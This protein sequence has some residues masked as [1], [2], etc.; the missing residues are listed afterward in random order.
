MYQINS[1]EHP[2]LVEHKYDLNERKEILL[3]K[4]EYMLNYK[5]DITI[6]SICKEM[7]I[8]PETLRNWGFNSVVAEMKSKQKKIKLIKFKKN[9]VDS[10]NK[11]INENKDTMISPTN[12]YEH[13]GVIRTVLWRSSPEITKLLRQEVVQHNMKIRKEQSY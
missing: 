13:L 3:S 4:L 5:I 7:N 10:A 6:E 11:Y 9:I 1:K 8:C 2:K 12:I